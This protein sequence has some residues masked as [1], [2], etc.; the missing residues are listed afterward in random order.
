MRKTPELV[1]DPEDNAIDPDDDWT[2]EVEGTPSKF[3]L[4]AKFGLA[5]GALALMFI[6]TLALGPLVMPGAMTAPYAERLI[7]RVAGVDVTIK[8]DHSFSILPFLKLDAENVVSKDDGPLSLNLPHLEIEFSALGVLSGSADLELFLLRQP[9]IHLRTA[10]MTGAAENAPQID[11]AWGWW[12]DMSLNNLKIED[13]AFIL[14]DDRTGRVVRLEKF[15]AENT[16]PNKEQVQDGLVIAGEGL[17][18]G[19]PVKLDAITS[20]PQLLVSGNRW[21]LNLTFS[22]GLLD[23]SFNGSIA[24]RERMVGEGQLKLSGRDVKAINDWIGPLLP[25]RRHGT[26]SLEASIDMA[27]DAID[28]RRVDLA[29]GSTSF[30]GSLRFEDLATGAPQINGNIQAET[31]DLGMADADDAM[32]AA[33]APLM[34]PG[35]PSGTIGLTWQRLIWRS[36][37]LGAGEAIIDR[38]PKSRRLSIKLQEAE[39]YGGKLRGSF[40]FDASEG[41]RAMNLEVRALGISIGPILDNAET[42]G[43]EILSGT[44]TIELNLFSVGG[45]PRELREALTGEAEVLI[46]G[47]EIAVE[48]L[49]RGLVPESGNTLPFK[50]LNGRF[51]I[52]QGIAVSED[53]LLQS[54]KLSL[55]GKG[56]IDLANWTIDLNIG[57]LGTDG[58]ARSLQ[59]YRV[60]GPAEQMRVEPVNG[61]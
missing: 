23:G 60:S 38:Q 25:A 43:Q 54:G 35:M 13:G 18:N 15:N 30:T 33:E 22:S 21:P 31:I 36:T 47:G 17:L 37:V 28:V 51:V 48:E 19:K 44:S 9:V 55:V 26:L 61:S 3:P 45:T 49:V 12:R 4:L 27:G 7:S 16:K 6:A 42:A 11:R 1:D 29:Y 53:L 41:M 10:R 24:L 56:Q 57:R 39:L 32:A 52:G 46:Q 14:S 5:L 8:G 50:S 40:T 59:R 20:N 34:V 2:V 58:D